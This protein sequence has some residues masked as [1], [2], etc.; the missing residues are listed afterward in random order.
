MC[1][2]YGIFL[3]HGRARLRPI[4]SRYGAR[5][6]HA[7]RLV[8]HAGAGAAG[9]ADKL[10]G[11]QQGAV[12][13]FH[14]ADTGASC[15]TTVQTQSD[16]GAEYLARGHPRGRDRLSPRR[17]RLHRAQCARACVL[18]ALD[19]PACHLSKTR[20]GGLVPTVFCR[21]R[22][23][24]SGYLRPG[25][26]AVLSKRP[27]RPRHRAR[28]RIGPPQSVVRAGVRSGRRFCLDN[29]RFLRA[30]RETGCRPCHFPPGGISACRGP[31]PHRG[32]KDVSSRPDHA[33][34]RRRL[35]RAWR[36]QCRRACVAVVGRA[37]RQP[38]CRHRRGGG[39][40]RRK[41]S[42]QVWCLLRGGGA[43]RAELAQL[44][45]G[46]AHVAFHALLRRVPLP[47]VSV[48]PL[49]P[50]ILRGIVV[51]RRDRQRGG[52]WSH[53]GYRS[54]CSRT[55][56]EGDPVAAAM[57]VAGVPA[58][59]GVQPG[60]RCPRLGPLARGAGLPMP[61]DAGSH[62]TARRSGP[63]TARGGREAVRRLG[64]LCAQ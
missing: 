19:R 3:H 20:P 4:P 52:L 54:R 53:E 42:E 25:R 15:E 47:A 33:W 37:S 43:T 1:T 44:E 22:V 50:S 46:V 14:N 18:C 34:L 21:D 17:T 62:A 49:L 9:R 27:R 30:A 10:P 31:V 38:D 32:G 29:G 2:S 36:G 6:E 8:V 23:A 40:G 26:V 64:P 7:L 45:A 56:K 16:S 28:R 35:A 41:A 51:P 48:P 59:G 58:Y 55:R 13:A 63:R 5:A 60:R 57:V 39:E 11:F 24:Y 61:Q 12:R